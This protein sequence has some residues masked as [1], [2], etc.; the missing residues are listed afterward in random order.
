MAS[1]TLHG[2]RLLFQV[3]DPVTNLAKT[4]GVFS[5]IEYS[6]SVGVANVNI[7]GRYTVAELVYVSS[8]PVSITA[9]GFRTIDHGAYVDAGFSSV[10][11][12]MANEYVQL[13]LVD[14]QTN[15]V[16]ARFRDAKAVSHNGGGS[17]G[18]LSN[19]VVQFTAIVMDDESVT[20]VEGGGVL[21]AAELP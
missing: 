1:K 3:I 7:L 17:Q 9:S 14:R 15:K 8:E 19:L 16:I 5:S 11:N 4:V 10:Q 2:A 12:L 21:P 6:A 18:S 13:Q 20:N